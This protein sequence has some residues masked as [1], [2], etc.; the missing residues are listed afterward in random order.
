MQ[1]SP[2]MK[3][4]RTSTPDPKPTPLKPTSNL[5]P[6]PSPSM[7]SLI[8]EPSKQSSE[9]IQ[10][11]LATLQLEVNKRGLIPPN[12]PR[13]PNSPS[14]T[15]GGSCSKPQD[16]HPNG[17]PP[18]NNPT[19]LPKSN[20]SILHPDKIGETIAKANESL[21]ETLASHGLLRTQTPKISQFSGDELNGN[22]SFEHW[23]YE[24]ESLR[25]AYTESAIKEAI[26]KS[27]KGS[28]AESL[29]SLGPL[30]TVE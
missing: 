23:E 27:L 3:F 30:A 9:S 7:D 10:V 15:S 29:R 14:P 6:S 20:D 26:T 21:V 12:P 24:I 17:N 2:N 5:N 8:Q 13:N 4:I 18:N 19:N 11:L 22:V 28:A 1:W 16:K 25:K